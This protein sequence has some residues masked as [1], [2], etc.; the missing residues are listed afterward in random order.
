M[1]KVARFVEQTDSTACCNEPVGP[2]TVA[3]G[4]TG[5]GGGR[6]G[7][8]IISKYVRPGCYA[9]AYNHYVLLRSLE[10]LFGLDHLGFAAQAGLK[11][12]GNDAYRESRPCCDE[13]RN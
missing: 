8:L 1:S 3:P 4:K 10:D 11:P 6:T 9:N 12:F 7:T 5:R 13:E 2:N